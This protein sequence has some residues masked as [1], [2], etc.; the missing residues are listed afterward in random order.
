VPHCLSRLAAGMLLLF[1]CAGAGFSQ[2]SQSVSWNPAVHRISGIKQTFHIKI[3]GLAAGTRWIAGAKVDSETGVIA[4]EVRFRMANGGA[5]F[6][7]LSEIVDIASVRIDS[8][9]VTVHP[10]AS[11]ASSVLVYVTVP[12]GTEVSIE[13]DGLQ[14]AR[15]ILESSLLVQDGSVI[16]QPLS[17]RQNLLSR[18]MKG[19]LPATAGELRQLGNGQYL[20]TIPALKS[21]LLAWS[22]PDAA[23]T[24]T[25]GSLGNPAAALELQIDSSGNV[26]DVHA[27]S[28][29]D[30]I[31]AVYESSVRSWRFKPFLVGGS[32][33]AVRGIV[34]FFVA[35]DGQLKT[36][37]HASVTVRGVT[38]PADA[39]SC[40]KK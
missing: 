4:N 32:P 7:P 3:D 17:G 25:A 16:P 38:S 1:G 8:D 5:P 20:A 28:G 23:K 34:P 36:P 18:L 14:M 35:S 19:D 27:R 2:Q 12:L 37:L 33:V 9:G 39:A 10:S 11:S 21:H 40:C 15:A 24:L 29:A 6:R 31:R 26:V 22:E 30:N 13:K